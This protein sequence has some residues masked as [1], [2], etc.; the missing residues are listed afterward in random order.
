V[1]PWSPLGGGLLT[2][3][4]R[5]DAEPDTDA[6]LL[7]DPIY[8]KQL[9]ER[10]LAIAEA[11]AGIAKETG[12]SSAQVA[13]N[14]VLHRRGVT[15]PIIGVRTAPQLDDNL[16]AEGWSLEPDHVAALVR[17]SRYPLPYPH[18]LYRTIGIRRYD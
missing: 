5:S 16:G 9:T 1:L 3:K 17:A 4:Y 15:A 10:N 14:W 12:Y 13:L 2:G 6:R 7:A 18:D 11:V 8:A